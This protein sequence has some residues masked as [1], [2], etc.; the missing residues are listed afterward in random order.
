MNPVVPAAS[1]REQANDRVG[2]SADTGLQRRTVRYQRFDLSGD[3]LFNLVRLA[4]G[5][6]GGWPLVADYNVDVGLFEPVR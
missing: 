2:D 5:Q 4:V 1:F 6:L 3:L